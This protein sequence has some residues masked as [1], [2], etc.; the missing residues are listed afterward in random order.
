MSK[1]CQF[2]TGGLKKMKTAITL[3]N[4]V[5][6]R[7]NSLKSNLVSYFYKSNKNCCFVNKDFKIFTYLQFWLINANCFLGP[8]LYSKSLHL[9]LSMSLLT[10]LMYFNFLYW[11][12]VQSLAFHER[13]IYKWL[14][15]V[16]SCQSIL[17]HYFGS[18]NFWKQLTQPLTTRSSTDWNFLKVIWN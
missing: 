9:V 15:C 5:E 4:E 17:L 1:T 11:Y 13:I 8:K 7:V 12:V 16:L 6:N 3:L 14:A 2:L 10:T 18:R